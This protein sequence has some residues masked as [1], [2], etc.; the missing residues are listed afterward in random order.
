MKTKHRRPASVKKRSLIN[1]NFTEAA[2]KTFK[3]FRLHLDDLGHFRGP[4]FDAV[5]DR[6]ART[7]EI[8]LHP[9]VYRLLERM[10]ET[11]L[12]GFTIID[13]AEEMIRRSI[14]K[15]LGTPI[16]PIE[17]LQLSPKKRNSL[18]TRKRR[19]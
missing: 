10:V 5:M 1:V 2:K 14:L 4:A 11:G 3:G 6:A 19:A 15:E 16:L 17:R 7:I 18:T 12:F 9:N 13:A 8:E